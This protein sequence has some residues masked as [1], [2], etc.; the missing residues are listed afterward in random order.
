MPDGATYMAGY[1]GYMRGAEDRR[2]GKH[3][4]ENPFY[5]R[6][7]PVEEAAWA[8]GWLDQDEALAR[9]EER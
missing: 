9:K 5:G 2:Q 4:G 1:T 8:D 7:M 3:H 6:D